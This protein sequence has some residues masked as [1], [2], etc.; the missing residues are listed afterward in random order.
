[1]MKLVICGYPELGEYYLLDDN[2]RMVPLEVDAVDTDAALKD[3]YGIVAGPRKYG[4]KAGRRTATQVF[5][6]EIVTVET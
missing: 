6:D 4:I 3:K 5:G 2:G 1:M